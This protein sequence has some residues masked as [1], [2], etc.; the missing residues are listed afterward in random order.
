L[1]PPRRNLELKALDPD[2]DTTL[3]QALALGA[4][5]EG[6]VHQ[7]D[8]Y[9]H[10][11]Q[12]RLKLR[13]QLHPAD[14]PAE[15]I[16][17]TRADRA[18]ARIS[19]YRVV[20]ILDPQ[21]LAEALNDVLGVRTVVEKRRRLLIHHDTRIHLDDVADL[22]TFVELESTQRDEQRIQEIRAALAITDDRLI[23]HGYADMLERRGRA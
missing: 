21:A 4:H 7:R 6:T 22:G 3:E 17:Y 14:T 18:D 12:G 15:L 10:A 5:D 20:T 16:S 13:E 23:A 2:P 8:I 19:N 1:S 11:V 9:F